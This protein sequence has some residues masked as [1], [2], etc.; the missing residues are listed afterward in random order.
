[1]SEVLTAK[2]ENFLVANRSIGLW[3]AGLSIA[4]TWIWAPALFVAAQQAYVNGFWGLFWFTVPNILALVFFGGFALTLRQRIP[5]GYTLSGYMRDR[6]SKRTQHAYHAQLLIQDVCAF[7]VQLV[8]GGA[9]IAGITGWSYHMIVLIMA[10]VVL[11]YSLLGGLK[12]SIFT[13]HVQMII[14]A[15]V[16][17]GISI[18]IVFLSGGIPNIINGFSGTANPD[19]WMLML[20]FGIPSA[21]ILFA[22]PFGFSAFWQRGL[23]L[24]NPN[25][26]RKSYHLGA[27][28]FAIV[29]IGLGLVG[30]AA[31]GVNLAVDDVQLT[32]LTAVQEFLPAWVVIPFTVAI[33]MGLMSTLDSALSGASSVW[34]H[35]FSETYSHRKAQAG[36]T[37]VALLATAVAFIPGVTIL[38]LWFFYGTSRAATMMPTI[39]TLTKG[40]VS[41]QITEKGMFFGI[42]LGLIFGAPVMI[43]GQIT[44]NWQ[45]GLLGSLAAVGLSA[46]IVLLTRK[47]EAV[48][49]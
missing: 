8:A 46:G 7:A 17:I 30:F 4:A 48:E 47:K 9:I 45:I 14:I 32:N 40:K 41:K 34:G 37:L 18:P 10:V 6:Y 11:A 36:M 49:A 15:A 27:G 44:K 33:L 3:T 43:Y 29:P 28:V 16:I 21:I 23:A 31:A 35:D 2:K 13:D 24:K 12:A 19:P 1:M 38:Y 26:V 20:S 22:G 39:L 5:E 42:V 25:D